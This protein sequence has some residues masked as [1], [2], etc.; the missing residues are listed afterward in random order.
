MVTV[1]PRPTIVAGTIA[2]PLLVAALAWKS[3]RAPGGFYEREVYAMDS[4]VYRRYFFLSLGFALYFAIVYGMHRDAAGIAGLALYA[5]I[6]V[7]YATSFLRGASD[8]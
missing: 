2:V 5:L 3:S 7:L 6:A 8:E 4:S 1:M